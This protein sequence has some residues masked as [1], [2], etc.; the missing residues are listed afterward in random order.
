VTIVIEAAV[1][2]ANRAFY[3]AFAGRNPEAMAQVWAREHAVV[4]IHPGRGALRNREAVMGS[5]RA[6]LDSRDAPSVQFSDAAAIV[7]GDAAFVT[8][9][10]HI[11][12]ARLAATNIFA[13]E[14]GEWR[15][16]HHHAGP[17][18]SG[19]ESRRPSSSPL[20]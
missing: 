11:G 8:C 10:E 2:A 7:F 15:M 6:I 18:A 17:M 20:N 12:G 9:M 5:W 16:V 13:L 14:Q 1:L 4:C 19:G 3:D